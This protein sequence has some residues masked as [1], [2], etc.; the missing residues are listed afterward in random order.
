MQNL[1]FDGELSVCP[2][3]I[4]AR[5]NR[6][7]TGSANEISRDDII[8]LYDETIDGFQIIKK[9]S[10]PIPYCRYCNKAGKILFQWEGQYRKALE[11]H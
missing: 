8:D 11:R 6:A 5:G 10:R 3:P 1:L 9:F 4:V 2:A 7:L